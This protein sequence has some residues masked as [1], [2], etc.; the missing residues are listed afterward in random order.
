MEQY[1]RTKID[2]QLSNLGWILNGSGRNVFLEEART[3]E[4]KKILGGKRPDYVLYA[5]DYSLYE[6]L[7]IIEAKSSKTKGLDGAIEQAFV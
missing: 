6:P 4:E 1:V 7:A 5:S 3:K 2:T